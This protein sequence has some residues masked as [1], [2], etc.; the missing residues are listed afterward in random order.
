MSNTVY[1]ACLDY[2]D[3]DIA[4]SE[5]GFSRFNK[6]NRVKQ[7]GTETLERVGNFVLITGKSG[8]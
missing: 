2:A 8:L 4:K 6:L 3:E 5:I 7:Q 1:Y